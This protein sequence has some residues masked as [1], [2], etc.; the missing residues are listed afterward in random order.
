MAERH[1]KEPKE[2]EPKK[3]R[4]RRATTP[5]GREQQL[6]ALAVDVAEEMMRN[7]NAPAQIVTHYLKIGS[8]REKIELELKREEIEVAKMRRETMA[9][10]AR[11][12]TVYADALAAMREYQG[13][14]PVDNKDEHY[15]D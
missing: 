14:P 13:G 8:T 12:E 15:E 1:F 9:A 4:P 11:I 3:P 7:G 10:Q 6:V 5:E 2:P